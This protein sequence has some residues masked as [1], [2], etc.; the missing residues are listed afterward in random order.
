MRTP[1][2]QLRFGANEPRKDQ[3]KTSYVTVRMFTGDHIDTAI[4]VAKE[5]NIISAVELANQDENIACNASKLRYEYFA[6]KCEIDADGEL[7]YKCSKSEWDAHFQAFAK[8][9]KVIARCTPEDKL[10]F[11]K[12]L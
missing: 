8:N 3:F 6:D 4:A 2:N 1:I 7:Q 10:F 12:I 5:C 9:M 11:I